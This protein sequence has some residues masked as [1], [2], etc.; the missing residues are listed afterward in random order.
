M[1]SRSL[2]A[3]EMDRTGA[4]PITGEPVLGG[5]DGEGGEAGMGEDVESG[6]S[7]VVGGPVVV[8]VVGGRMG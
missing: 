2:L 4:R 7:I 6:C 8:V 1:A 5:W 3:I